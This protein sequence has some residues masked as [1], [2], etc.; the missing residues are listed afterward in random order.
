VLGEDI[1]DKLPGLAGRVLA[2]GVQ[3]QLAAILGYHDAVT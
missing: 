2:A 3:E 1:T